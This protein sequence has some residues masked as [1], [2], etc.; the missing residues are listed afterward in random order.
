MTM[1]LGGHVWS[2]RSSRSDGP[3]RLVRQ[4]NTRELRRGQRG[5]CAIKLAF[6]HFLGTIGISLRKHLSH[7][8]NRGKARLQ[9]GFGFAMNPRVRLAKVLAPLGM[10][11]DNARGIR[12]RPACEPRFLR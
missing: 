1:G 4:Q 7:A 3:H 12:P 5:K 6:Q 9:G 8:D 2:C 10:P 11:H